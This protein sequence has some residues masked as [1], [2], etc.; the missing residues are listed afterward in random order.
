[1]VILPKHRRAIFASAADGI[2]YLAPERETPPRGR[3]QEPAIFQNDQASV[4]QIGRM[5][6]R[7]L[8]QPA[9]FKKFANLENGGGVQKGETLRLEPERF[10]LQGCSI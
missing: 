5:S 7:R 6:P 9:S 2:A 8:E 1:M 10:A 3:R 4:K